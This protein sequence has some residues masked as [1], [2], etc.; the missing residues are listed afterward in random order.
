MTLYTSLRLVEFLTNRNDY[1]VLPQYFPCG[2]VLPFDFIELPK[3]TS[4]ALLK[5]HK[6]YPYGTKIYIEY[7][8]Q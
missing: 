8:I 6:G 5:E 7:E 1:V 4:H 2:N 3:S